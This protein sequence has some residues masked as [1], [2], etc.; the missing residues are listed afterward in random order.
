MYQDGVE[1]DM[2]GVQTDVK[3]ETVASLGERTQTVGAYADPCLILPCLMAM[4]T[5]R[6]FFRMTSL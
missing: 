1:V 3:R 2:N 6:S 5:Y 4:I